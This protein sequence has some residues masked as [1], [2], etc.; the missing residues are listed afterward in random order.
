MSPGANLRARLHR[1]R[2]RRVGEGAHAAP[3]CVE[4]RTGGGGRLGHLAP[5]D[6]HAA[7]LP[8]EI[9]DLGNRGQAEVV[10]VG[11]VDA[12]DQGVDQPEVHLGAEAGPDEGPQRVGLQTGTWSERLGRC[13]QLAGPGQQAR[14]GQR[15]HIGGHA[16]QQPLGDVVQAIPPHRRLAGRRRDEVVAEADLVGECGTP[17]DPGEECIGSLVD[18]PVAGELGGEELAAEP[19]V[20]LEH[21]DRQGRLG[22]DERESGRQPG[23]ATADDGDARR[24]LARAHRPAITRR[25]R[26]SMTS[27]SSFTHAVRANEMPWRA[28][29]CAASMSRS[30]NTSR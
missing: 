17:R 14:P 4:H 6:Q 28:A 20:G 3:R 1:S 30:Y 10:G 11:G 12:A 29:R 9:G 8:G 26:A 22:G 15:Q 24:P 18:G 23:D 16:E 19:V 2:R 7:A 27:A 25:A 5:L 13:P 21:G